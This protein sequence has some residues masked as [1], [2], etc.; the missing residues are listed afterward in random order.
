MTFGFVLWVHV[1]TCSV[2]ALDELHLCQSCSVV[3]IFADGVGDHSRCKRMISDF[4]L[5]AWTC[6]T[7]QRVTRQLDRILPALVAVKLAICIVR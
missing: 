4:N 7:I 5:C 6:S 1:G 2:F 3:N